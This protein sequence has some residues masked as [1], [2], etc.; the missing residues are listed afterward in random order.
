MK[1]ERYLVMGRN[2]IL[3]VLKHDP[4]RIELLYTSK[5]EEDDL[6]TA[7][8]AQGIEIC[9]KRKEGLY[10]MI[11]S[12]SHQ[13]YIAKLKPPIQ[14]ELS[15]FLKSVQH[16]ERSLI[17]MMDGITDPQNVGAILRAGECFGV[18]GF[19]LGKHN[20]CPMTPVVSKVSV[21]ASELL[22]MVF[23]GSQVQ[24]LETCR[25]EGYKAVT[26]EINNA[27]PIG[28]FTFPDKTLLILGA[29]GLGVQKKISDLSDYKI[30]VPMHG[31]IDSL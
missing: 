15:A 25:K 13:G 6:V 24:A 2:C 1:K 22:P 23:V 16:L 12:E 21:G 27:L 18:D 5:D 28:E 26:M 31:A 14:W 29:E 9:Y 20:C 11:E 19:I 7:V 8:K 17:I 10:L 4:E 30:Y 3:E